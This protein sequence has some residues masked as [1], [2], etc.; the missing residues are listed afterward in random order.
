MSTT[1]E[2]EDG[3]EIDIHEII[4][5]KWGVFV[6]DG[7]REKLIKT[8]PTFEKAEEYVIGRWG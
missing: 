4:P 7:A 5:G 2:T 6:T 1:F 8:F 3:K